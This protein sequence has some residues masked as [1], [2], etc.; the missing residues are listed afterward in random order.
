MKCPSCG[1]EERDD[2]FV[3]S[4]CSN[5]LQKEG[6]V[7]G[8]TE[9]RVPSNVLDELK[10]E[11]EQREKAK[12]E[13]RRQRLKGHAITGALTFSILNILFGLPSSLLPLNLL[14]TVAFS[15]VVGLPIGY[16]ISSRGGGVLKGACMSAGAFALMRLIISVPDLMSSGDVGAILFRALS[17]GVLMGAIPG[18]IIGWHVELGR[19]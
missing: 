9:A 13:W 12:D 7:P 6:K 8:T 4:L 10:K 17:V 15:T 16:L 1:H 18:A 14:A 19:G 5:L 11:K 2:V 3:C